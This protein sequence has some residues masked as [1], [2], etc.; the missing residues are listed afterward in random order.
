MMQ[1]F[2]GPGNPAKPVRHRHRHLARA[3]F[4]A[5]LFCLPLL[6]FAAAPAGEGTRVAV[7]S[8]GQAKLKIVVA[9]AATE[10][11]KKHAA[12]LAD[13]LGKITGAKFVT[14][15]G[16]GVEGIAVGTAADFPKAPVDGRFAPL[17]PLRRDEYI[18]KTHAKGAW[19][20]GVSDIAVGHAVWDFLYRLGYRQYFAG[21]NWEIIPARRNLDAAMNVFGTPSYVVRD[22]HYQYGT[23]P[24]NYEL[25][26]KWCVRNRTK[27]AFVLRNAHMYGGIV[28]QNKAAF[29]SHPEYYGL[30]KGKRVGIKF[31]ISNPEA[32]KLAVAY[33]LRYFEEHPNEDSCSLEP[34]D[35]GGWCECEECAKLGGISNRTALLADECAA[36]VQAKY[37]TSKYIGMLAYYMHF[38]PPSFGVS[39]QVIVCATT[40]L[41]D[42]S[43]SIDEA[44]MG[45]NNRGARVGF[46]DYYSVSDWHR[47]RPGVPRAANLD[48]VKNGIVSHYNEGA[49]FFT[50]EAGDCWGPSGLGYYLASRYLWDV[51]EAGRAKE[52]QSEFLDL[53]FKAAAKPMGEFY[54]LTDGTNRAVQQDDIVGRMYRLLDEARKLEPDPGVRARIDDLVQYTHYVELYMRYITLQ[55]AKAPRQKEFEELIRYIYSIRSTCMVHGMA[56]AQSIPTYEKEFKLPPEAAPLKPTGPNPPWRDAA[57]P[58]PEEIARILKDGIAANPLLPFKALFCSTDLV[59]AAKALHLPAVTPGHYLL[60]SNQSWFTWL[61]PDKQRFTVITEGRGGGKMSMALH[62]ANSPISFDL[63]VSKTVIEAGEPSNDGDFTGKPVELVSPHAGL[64][65]LVLT[66]PKQAE[67]SGIPW[68]VSATANFGPNTDMYFY[69]PRGT[70]IIAGSSYG[71]RGHADSGVIKDSAGNVVFEFSQITEK[72]PPDSKIGT[73]YFQVPVPP[74]MDGGLWKM[75]GIAQQ[76]NLLTVPPYYARSAEELLL[77]KE[78]VERDAKGETK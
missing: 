78:V 68:T 70:K 30:W 39:P 15:V 20:V 5:A 43:M 31:C 23:F 17:D 75:E 37:G 72:L 67:T 38:A 1:N 21:T 19:L 22:I 8:G 29:D 44:I 27:S 18:L 14:E 2:A 4:S 55:Y 64:H 59:P 52:L 65:R 66:G 42:G 10:E 16:D 40:S 71:V 54:E 35:G 36:A 69:V 73:A 32:R 61:E 57:P 51:S 41:S 34:T 56:L 7:A 77:P 6:A 62:A 47:D 33:V 50:A 12:D 53:C 60:L 24:A 45:W 63:P 48:Y 58:S 28:A 49:R 13:M 9:P 26:K 25:Y 46:Y 11:V 76:R 74:G 3:V